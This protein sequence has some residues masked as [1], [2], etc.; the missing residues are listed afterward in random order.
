M[1]WMTVYVSSTSLV[2]VVTYWE[3]YSSHQRLESE[4][5]LEGR[6][7]VIVFTNISNL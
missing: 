1:N 5:G 2:S 7:T 3:E 6:R 4:E